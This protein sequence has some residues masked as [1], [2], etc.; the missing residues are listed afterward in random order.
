MQPSRY[1]RLAEVKAFICKPST[2]MAGFA[3]WKPEANSAAPLVHF[4]AFAA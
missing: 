1:S 4:A 2:N 3:C